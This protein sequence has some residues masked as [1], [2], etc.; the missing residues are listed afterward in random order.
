MAESMTPEV[1]ELHDRAARTA[2]D[3]QGQPDAGAWWTLAHD[4]D[5]D[6]QRFARLAVPGGGQQ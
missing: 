2:H 4:L 3:H 6:D 1:S 5:P